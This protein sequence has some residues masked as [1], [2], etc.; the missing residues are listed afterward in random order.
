MC[1]WWWY[2]FFKVIYCR[3][4]WSP[5]NETVVVFW[6]LVVLNSKLVDGQAHMWMFINQSTNRLLWCSALCTKLTF[7]AA[8][9]ATAG[10]AVTAVTRSY[11]FIKECNRCV[12]ICYSSWRKSHLLCWGST[13]TYVYT[14]SFAAP[15]RSVRAVTTKCYSKI[16]AAWHSSYTTAATRSAVTGLEKPFYVFGVCGPLWT[17]VVRQSIK[18]LAPTCQPRWLRRNQIFLFGK[19]TFCLENLVSGEMAEIWCWAEI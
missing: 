4:P 7:L 2:F 6:L 18:V 10:T 11:S 13:M 14:T 8:M 17:T 1:R 3:K 9:V 19:I 12:K 15:Q 16:L 5:D